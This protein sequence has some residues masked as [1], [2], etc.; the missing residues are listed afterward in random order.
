MFGTELVD[1]LV[2]ADAADWSA[3][4]A[5]PFIGSFLG[6]VVRR[7]PDGR[8]IARGRS[9]CERC[10]AT[11]AVRDLVPLFSWL[12]AR[13]RCRFCGRP[14]GWFYPGI[15]LAAVAVAVTS[16]L[17]DSGARA[18]LDCMLGW[19]LLALGWIDLQRWLLPD[20]LTL[21]LVVAGLAA[22]AFD[23]DGLTDRAFGAAAGYL[24]LR[25]VAFLYRAM[26]GR[27]G[28][29][30]GDAKLLAAAGAWVG[31]RGLPQVVLLAALAG[32]C[33]AACLRLA[34]VRLGAQSALPFGPFLAFA[35]WLVWLMPALVA[36]SAME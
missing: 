26:R 18:W 4:L 29:G 27:E 3:V 9:C 13:G 11:L 28:L 14:L 1:R 21:P 7:L 33:A 23:L 25:A 22:A 10:G 35:I 20:A 2:G 16:V 12:A 24:G 17:V 6:V 15:E 36:I 30:Q 19:W 31:V 5:A 34:G 8:P 32:L